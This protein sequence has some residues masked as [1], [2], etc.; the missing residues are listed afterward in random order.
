MPPQ[1][2]V[3]GVAGGF[4]LQVEINAGGRIPVDGYPFQEGGGDD[5]WGFPRSRAEHSPAEFPGG[6]NQAGVKDSYH[7]PYFF[8]RDFRSYRNSLL[9]AVEDDIPGVAVCSLF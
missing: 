9:L 8:L 7:G 4:W 3:N 6:L 5:C 2:P 1:H